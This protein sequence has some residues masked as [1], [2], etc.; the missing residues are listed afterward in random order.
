ME[1]AVI[2]RKIIATVKAL[3]EAREALQEARVRELDA[4][5]AYVVAEARAWLTFEG[6]VKEKDSRTVIA[7]SQDRYAYDKAALMVKTTQERI[8]Q[9]EKEFDASQSLSAIERAVMRADGTT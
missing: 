8:R 1:L 7:V 6:S 5:E 9:L 3:Q 2:S 4:K